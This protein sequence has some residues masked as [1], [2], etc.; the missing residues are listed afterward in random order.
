MGLSSAT[1]RR[2]KRLPQVPNVWEGA[3]IY[4]PGQLASESRNSGQQMIIWMDGSE[5]IA[6]SLGSSD[7]SS[8]NEVMVRSLLR[9]I[10]YPQGPYPQV[11]PKKVLVADREE[12]FYLRGVLNELDIEVEYVPELP[13]IQHL[14]ER[15]IDIQSQSEGQL[16]AAY[17]D[18]LETAAH[19]IWKAAPWKTLGDYQILEIEIN[20]WDVDRFYACVMGMMGQEYG[21]LLYR[22][23]ESVSQ[24]R[25]A[26]AAPEELDDMEQA[27][28]AQDC[29]YLA[30]DVEEPSIP[31][32]GQLKVVNPYDF[33]Y[34]SIHPLE[35]MRSELDAEE[36][37]ATYVALIA[38][39]KFFTAL[40]KK[41][42][43]DA[44][45][46]R[47]I[48]ISL[49]PELE[50]P[51]LEIEV[52]V[53][54]MPEFSEQLLA[55]G[56]GD[57]DDDDELD[58]RDDL[59][60]ER[61][62]ISTG[63]LGWELLR[64]IEPTVDRCT[65][66]FDKPLAK[67]M[68]I[69]MVQSTRPAVQ[70]TIKHIVASQGIAAIIFDEVEHPFSGEPLY[71]GIAMLTDGQFQLIGEFSIDQGKTWQKS[72]KQ[73]KGRCALIVAQ[74]FTSKSKLGPPRNG[75]ILAIWEAPFI[76]KKDGVI[77]PL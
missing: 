26:A 37:L 60:P 74:G 30:F 65:V 51:D 52:V 10:E 32:L 38:L 40:K 3:K 70:K 47:K 19:T 24:F 75:D 42:T 34:G 54:T 4:L 72:C 1:V 16:P 68:P 58:L 6:R 39:Q 15:F 56:G 61:C 11:R 50:T 5:G 66:D 46:Q 69:V 44:P 13:T 77:Q 45:L 63:T 8:G 53:S 29:I 23:M 17:V 31:L 36:A 48:K 21:V 2:L 18:L 49:P 22:S 57:E 28:L 71:L 14:L 35:G 7:E 20:R 59:L 25:R 64:S 41:I 76:R 43:L 12:L 62:A 73:S 27:F 33:T 55:L 67:G 9:A